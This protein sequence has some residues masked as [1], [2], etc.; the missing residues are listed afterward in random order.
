MYLYKKTFFLYY[1]YKGVSRLAEYVKN[2]FS[3]IISVDSIITVFHLD[4]NG[5]NPIGESHNFWEFLYVDRGT[6]KVS[7]DN[8]VY[9]VN[10]GQMIMYSPLA[11]HAAFGPSEAKVN[12]ISFE[13]LSET[14][15]YFANKVITLSGKQRQ[16]LSQIMSL[17]DECFK[18]VA[19]NSDLKGMVFREETNGFKLQNLKNQLELFLIDIYLKDESTSSKPSSSNYENHNSDTFN[20]LTEYLKDNIEKTLS[21]EEICQNCTISLSKLKRM[22]QKQCG[23][24]PMSYFIS[25]KIAAAKAMINDSSLNFTQISEK[26]GFSSV[27]YFSKLFKA[28]VGVSPSEYARSVYKK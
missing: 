2:I 5:K 16:M 4:L 15:S 27:H 18:I 12:I 13:S 10:E 11:F 23:M 1:M 7:V 22:C 25:L 9:T 20:T 26:L 14:M 3:D 21:L 8:T 24:S 28:K 17:G 19:P 6:H